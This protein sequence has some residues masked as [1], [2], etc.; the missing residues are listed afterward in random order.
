[1]K[2]Y[3][4]L[5]W[6]VSFV[7]GM[8]VLGSLLTNG[9]IAF[10][11]MDRVV[12]V[13]GLSEREYLADKVIWPIHLSKASNDLGQLTEQLAR[14]KLKLRAFLVE[15]G[16]GV[17]EISL[18]APNV[19]DKLSQQYSNDKPTFRYHGSQTLTV[20]SNKVETVRNVMQ[21]MADLLNQGVVLR[22]G[23]NYE[24]EYVFTRLNEVKPDMIEEATVNARL[25]AD[26][27]AADS[28]SRLGK[29][30]RA[31]QGRFSITPRD[32]QHPHIKNVRVVSTIEYNL[33]D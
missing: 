17:E 15:Q 26:K 22:G 31:N 16:I 25:V 30:K 21:N 20:Y 1:M 24:V 28:G 14:D 19:T 2:N 8:A 10:K 6:P 27:F 23:Y 4:K 5:V 11:S 18:S 32:S 12:T 7:L 33:V 13:K 3:S 29:I 9:I